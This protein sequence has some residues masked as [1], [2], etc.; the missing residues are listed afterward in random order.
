M[1]PR[2]EMAWRNEDRTKLSIALILVAFMLR[3][4]LRMNLGG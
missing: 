1:A 3:A 2:W 4:Y